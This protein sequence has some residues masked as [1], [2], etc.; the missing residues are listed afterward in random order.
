MHKEL[1]VMKPRCN[2]LWNWQGKYRLLFRMPGKILISRV[3]KFCQ[4]MD[5]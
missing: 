2:G 1:E 3:E 5:I 4:W